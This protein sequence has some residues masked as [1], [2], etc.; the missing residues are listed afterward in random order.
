MNADRLRLQVFDLLVGPE[1]GVAG[2]IVVA[3]NSPPSER[4]GRG[5]WRER[6]FPSTAKAAAFLGQ[7]AQ[8]AE[9]YAALARFRPNAGAKKEAVVAKACI[10][11]DVDLAR[12]PGPN[13]TEQARHLVGAIPCPKI[14]IESGGGLHPH[15]LLPPDDRVEAYDAP[16]DGIRH[17]EI[18]GIALRLFLEDQA[19]EMF[20]ARVALDH[21]HGAQ[22]VWRIPP[23]WNCK[24]DPTSRELTADR[25]SWREVRLLEPGR[26][27]GLSH[28]AAADLSFLMPYL[29]AA[30]EAWDGGCVATP[31]P[32]EAHFSGSARTSVAVAANT[33]DHFDP[34]VLPE[35]LGRHWPQ[36]SGDQSGNDFALASALAKAG[37]S[38][39]TAARAI[40]LRRSLL[41][42]AEDRAKG[43]RADY[44]ERTVRKAYEDHLPLPPPSLPPFEPFPL[45]CLPPPL[46]RY[47]RQAARAMVCAPEAILLPLLAALGAAIGNTRRIQ[48]KR[49]W[50]EPALLWC[51][52]ILG[53]GKLK[54]PAQ[55]AALD[56]LMTRQRKALKRYAEER[57]TW[58]AEV[59]RHKLRMKEYRKVGDP[60]AP[61]P[62]RPRPPA[63][64][65]VVV[66]D[67]TLEGLIPILE[68][69]PRGLLLTRDELGAWLRSFDAYRKGRGGDLQQWLSIHRAGE[70]IVDRKQDRTFLHVRWGFVGICGGIQ[71]STLRRILRPEFF[72]CGLAARLLMV[73]PKAPRRRWSEAVVDG[74]LAAALADVFTRLG[75]LLFVE[76]E[77][78]ER[79]PVVMVLAPEAKEL[80]IRR[81]DDFAARM[82]ALPEEDA[83]GAA[84]SKLEGYTA[85]LA[86]IFTLVEWA[87]TGTGDPPNWVDAE[88]LARAIRAAEWFSHETA[89]VY[90]MLGESPEAAE[91]RD[92]LTWVERRGGSASVRDLMRGPRRYRDDREGAER[93]LGRAVGLGH[94]WWH[95]GPPPKSGGR[96]AQVFEL[97][98]ASRSG[99]DGDTR[100]ARGPFHAGLGERASPGP[101]PSTGEDARRDR[102]DPEVTRC[103][104]C[105]VLASDAHECE[106]DAA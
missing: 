94:G 100:S 41:E 59:E 104:R 106:G 18:L 24:A 95:L 97:R 27:E 84:F 51:L 10:S 71:P 31:A 96:P 6:R 7:H 83:L 32:A 74:H 2:E 23:G 19:R 55:E 88:N 69:N 14:T 62:E 53:S 72:E 102:T 70:V 75:S 85:R 57:A 54:S 52:V 61:P 9:A 63:R 45:D 65:R 37:W 4:C 25:A 28:V 56:A 34:A 93:I 36:R 82:D 47:L 13:H 103:P 42:R 105:G 98:S 16:E 30:E 8:R 43:A 46:G 101:V 40:R 68:E 77:S 38:P 49:G 66:S 20:G 76:D 11:A 87:A 35:N 5:K 39:E 92:L 3:T 21:C 26:I 67:T 73:Y 12:M 1:S 99:G 15:L 44:V 48:L 89:R 33:G 81:Y 50:T 58:E 22:R 86:L 60:E 78:G 90:A 79:V 17:V 80:W 91:L 64:E 29:R